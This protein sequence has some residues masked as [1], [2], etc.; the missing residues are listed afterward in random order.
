M[1]DK[2]LPFAQAL[3]SIADESHT[4]DA[5]VQ[6]F[7]QLQQIEKDNPELEPMLSHPGVAS[8]AKESL[9]L[10]L[11]ADAPESYRDF[12]KV[13]CRHHMAGRLLQIG[14][15][16]EKLVDESRDI[17]TVRVQSAAPLDESQKER[18][19]NALQAKLGGQVRLQ[20]SVNPKLIA[21][22]RIETGDSVMD[23][24]YQGLLDKMKEQLDKS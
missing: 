15:D 10:Q 18:L 21:G 22:M 14:E 16:F 17:K 13:V 11:F 9:L 23:A 3:F 4:L 6:Q 24:S 1:V 5:Y 8:S 20:C 19:T 12:L 7:Q 2:S